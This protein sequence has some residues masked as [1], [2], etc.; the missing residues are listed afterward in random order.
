VREL[1][2]ALIGQLEQADIS[3]DKKLK[4]AFQ[5]S[6]AGSVECSKVEV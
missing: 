1:S 2:D 4:Q 6:K 3:R 5:N